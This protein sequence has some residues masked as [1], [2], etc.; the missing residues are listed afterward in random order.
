M[1]AATLFG[2]LLLAPQAAAPAQDPKKPDAQKPVETK[3][4]KAERIHQ[5][6]LKRD[7][8]TGAKY[9]AEADKQFKASTN[10]EYIARVQKIGAVIADIANKTPINVL[11]G[12]KRLNPFHYTYKVIQGDDVNAF[13]LPGGFIYVYEGL[14]K[15]VESDDELAGVLA[16]ETAHAS[17]RHVST[18]QKEQSKMQSI[19]LP[20]VL[21]AILTG[22]ASAAGNAL[23]L[24]SLVMQATG[25]GWSV[26]AEESAD[27]GGFQYLLKS[28][29]DPTGML[30]FMEK[31]ARRNMLT[32]NIDWGIYKS[33][34][35]SKERADT[36][37]G[38]MNAAKIPIRRS[39]VAASY[40]T[41]VQDA[42]GGG[43]ELRYSGKTLV[44]FGGPDAKARATAAAERVNEFFDSQP[45]LFEL[46]KGDNG[47]ILGAGKV[48][49]QMTSTDVLPSVASVDQGQTQ[50]MKAMQ[51]ALYGI[52]SRIWDH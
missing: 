48:L 18:L 35:P 41:T 36:L 28:P 29:Y 52:G 43:V 32:D 37:T 7:T 38:Y 51:L 50:A 47:Q 42:T 30:T 40:R 26:K 9:S 25:S 19:S 22:G 14:L 8:E 16:H 15:Q 46:K 6:D 3:E 20:L 21:L 5:E 34:P 49:F 2:S 10:Q 12:D 24:S 31:L 4:Q 13:S 39:R 17:E 45:Q 33:H 27:Y 11:W 1:L 23:G 44:T